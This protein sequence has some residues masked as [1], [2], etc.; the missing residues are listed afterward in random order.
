[1]TRRS[2]ALV[3]LAF[4]VLPLLG[5]ACSTFGSD[6]PAPPPSSEG[7]ASTDPDGGPSVP[8]TPDRGLQVVV[9]DPKAIAYV[10]QGAS[11]ALPVK[12]T[13]RDSSTG[14]VDI[15]LTKLPPDLTADPLTIPAGAT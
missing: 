7:G 4:A 11:L 3:P 12:L 2:P 10:I 15:T 5:A 9:G 8:G 13:R 6:E 1:M 14:A